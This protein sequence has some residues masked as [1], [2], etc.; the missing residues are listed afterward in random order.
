MGLNKAVLIQGIKAANEAVKNMTDEN[1]AWNKWVEILAD[2]IEAYI[3]TGVV[4]TTG[5][6]ASQTGKIT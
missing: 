3:K 2:T 1:E 4:I 6:A 5:T